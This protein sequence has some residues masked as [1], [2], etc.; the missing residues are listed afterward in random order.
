MDNF[1]SRVLTEKDMTQVELARRVNVKREYINR[2][3]SGKITPKI[4]LGIKI[5][6]ALNKK[7]EDIFI[8]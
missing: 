2:I 4:P 6:S 3:I 1:I 5:A 7:V 8:I